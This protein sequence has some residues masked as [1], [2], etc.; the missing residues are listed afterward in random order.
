MLEILS[1]KDALVECWVLSH[2][3]RFIYLL[4]CFFCDSQ[5]KDDIKVKVLL[6][7]CNV[8]FSVGYLML[9]QMREGWK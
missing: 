2:I 9:H 6:A 5:M 1:L 8:F 7:S 4:V 3:T